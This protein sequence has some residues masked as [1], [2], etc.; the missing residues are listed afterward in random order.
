MR[1]GPDAF[2]ADVAEGRLHIARGE[3]S[4]AA[5]TIT[6]AVRV[7]QDLVFGGRDLD[8]AVH[9][10]EAAITGDAST[11]RRFLRCFAS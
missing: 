10:A 11:L 9:A 8:D 2:H 6:C 7:L 5:A 4:D 1:L 3:I